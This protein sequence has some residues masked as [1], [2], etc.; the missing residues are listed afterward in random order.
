[1]PDSHP[2]GLDH[3][4]MTTSRN[5]TEIMLIYDDILRR[6]L[7]REGPICRIGPGLDQAIRTLTKEHEDHD[8]YR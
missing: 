4:F 3:L 7:F 1:M 5:R 8:Q 2:L 6:D